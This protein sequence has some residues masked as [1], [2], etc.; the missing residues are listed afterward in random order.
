[1]L[2][3]LN[4]LGEKI[5]PTK[6]VA[7]YCPCCNNL[8]RKA[9]GDVIVH[10]WKH[11]TEVKCNS[12]PMTRWHIEWQLNF[13]K[14]NVEVY[15]NKQ[16][17]ADILTD[18]GM[19]IEF[20]HSSILISEVEKRSKLCNGNI[21]WVHDYQKQYNNNQFRNITKDN[22][23]SDLYRSEWLNPCKIFDRDRTQDKGIYI[24]FT[25]DTLG[26]L[27]WIDYGKEDNKT[28]ISFYKV[29]KAELV[30]YINSKCKI[31][32]TSL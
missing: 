18:D 20:Q 28:I 16:R 7:A 32:G 31:Y 10:H 6:D 12:K 8:V 9:M 22:K 2:Y 3:A 11:I 27:C 29:N 4:E 14:E 30:N 25:E 24:Q 19:A 13:P 23:I 1:M 26:R 17:R 21:I 15:V 5:K